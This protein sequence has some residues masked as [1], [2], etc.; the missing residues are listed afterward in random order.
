MPIMIAFQILE[1][2]PILHRTLASYQ[3]SPSFH[4]LCILLA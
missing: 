1:T 2:Y 4:P 3:S